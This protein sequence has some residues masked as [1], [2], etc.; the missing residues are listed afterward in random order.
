MQQQDRI[1]KLIEWFIKAALRHA[2]AI[3]AIQEEVAGLQVAALTKYFKALQGEAGWLPRFS[4]L[5]QHENPVIAGMC[6]VYALPLDP[7]RC[8]PVLVRLAQMPGL[9]GFR[10]QVALQRWDAGEWQAL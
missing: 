10:S 2:E 8:R 6:A 3:E 4:E 5:L 9:I 1:G 7:E